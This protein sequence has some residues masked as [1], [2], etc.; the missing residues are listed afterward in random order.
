ML[1]PLRTEPVMVMPSLP[2]PAG[3][4]VQPEEM[5]KLGQRARGEWPGLP[6]DAHALPGHLA[7]PRARR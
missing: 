5:R 1:A 3:E 2:V 7:K 6:T 4:R